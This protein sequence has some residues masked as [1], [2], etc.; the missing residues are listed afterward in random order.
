MKIDEADMISATDISRNTGRYVTQAAA[1]R[2]FVIMN[3]HQ[4]VVALIGMA[5]LRRLDE[6]DHAA[7]TTAAPTG[8][9]PQEVSLDNITTFLGQIPLGVTATGAT[10][11]LDPLEHLLVVGKGASDTIGTLL[12]GVSTDGLDARFVIAT[13]RTALMAGPGRAAAITSMT[14]ALDEQS[15][16]R[17][18]EQLAG[19]LEDRAELLRRHN[20][21]TMEK[22]RQ[23]AGELNA[24]ADLARQHNVTPPGGQRDLG[25]MKSVDYLFVVIDGADEALKNPELNAVVEQIIRRGSDFGVF[26]WL[27][28]PTVP[29][30][31]AVGTI[32]Q[33]VALK[34]ASAAQSRDVVGVGS[35][36]ELD[37]HQGIAKLEFG[38]PTPFTFLSFE[39]DYPPS[40]LSV[41][42]ND[43]AEWPQRPERLTVNQVQRFKYRYSPDVGLPVG[44]LD[45][46][47][48][49]RQSAFTLPFGPDSE[50]IQVFATRASRA[51]V[52][53]FLGVVL[54]AAE[55]ETSMRFFY[56]GNR[57]PS[58]TE[59]RNL[60]K[61]MPAS[62]VDDET[63]AQIR[64]ELALARDRGHVGP[65]GRIGREIVTIWDDWSHADQEALWNRLKEQLGD[66][67]SSLR[68]IAIFYEAK[69]R[70]RTNDAIYLAG[71]HPSDALDQRSQDILRRI[72][73]DPSRIATAAG[74]VVL[75]KGTANAMFNTMRR[76][77]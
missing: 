18:A 73:N 60:I 70:A 27:T 2:R 69:P 66:D 30:S 1:G 44:L 47:R 9:L 13:E 49:R 55:S 11:N 21:N 6:L 34:T 42:V 5:D 10:V 38:S 35:A 20:V 61:A 32:V 14:T 40:Y 72:R 22:Y 43:D 25:K 59:N 51:A 28:A 26:A 48:G 24:Q 39:N 7:T 29:R 77:D 63:I 33:R 46:V 76:D 15:A 57:P 52:D 37:A 68:T 23:I 19:E 74:P 45:D 56:F 71:L 50:P 31:D 54:A 12:W 62:D 67:F 65:P 41:N 17:L 75:L 16:A 64:D 36:S 58:T 53:E 8:T 4:P 3:N